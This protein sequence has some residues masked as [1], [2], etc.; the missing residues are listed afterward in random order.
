MAQAPGPWRYMMQPGVLKRSC[1]IAVVVGLA[2]SG[3]NQADVILY[4]ELT[5]VLAV[6]L[7]LN[8]V[9]PFVVSS[10]SAAA[11]RPTSTPPAA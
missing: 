7:V 1:T 11:N 8:F 6:K 4:G 10:V 5:R 9:V 2:L 3:I